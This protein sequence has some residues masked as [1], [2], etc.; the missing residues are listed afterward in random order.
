MGPRPCGGGAAGHP[1][2][3]FGT[4]GLTRIVAVVDEPNTRSRRLIERAGFVRT[5]DAVGPL[6]RLV[7]YECRR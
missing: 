5:G 2:H 6:H 7:L 3:E 1:P 4:L